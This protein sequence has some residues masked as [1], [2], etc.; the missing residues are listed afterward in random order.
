MTGEPDPTS[1]NDGLWRTGPVWL[2]SDR[3]LARFVGRPVA[4]FLRVEAAGGIVLLMAAVVALAWANSP[5][6][7]S[8][9]AL[10]TT[11]VALRIGSWELAQEAREWVNDGLM[12]LFFLAVGLEIKY[13][14]VSGELRD[15]RSAAVPIVAALGGMVVPAALYAALNTGGEGSAG[16]GIPMAT[17]IAF[18]LG[19]VALLGRRIP[20]PA[21]VFLLTLAIV[22]DIGAVAVIGI[23]Y[24]EDLSL[25]WLGAAVAGV[26][27]IVVLR[28]LRVWSL[29][30]YLLAGGFLWLA[31]ELS[32]VHATI[33]GVVLG[34]LAPAKPLLDEERARRY[35]RE[36]A[37]EQ[38]DAADVRRYR[39]LLGESVP[40]A[41]RLEYF[42]HPW[43]SFVVLP[44][45]ALANAG[46]DLSAEVL[47]DAAA[48]AVTAGVLLGLVVG[49]PLGI[50]SAS[51][52]TV[53]LGLGQL[54]SSMTWGVLSGL[55]ML[56]G[57]GFTVSLFI[58]GLAFPPG[59]LPEADAKVGIL[60]ASCLAALLGAATL[61]AASRRQRD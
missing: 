30:P 15:P 55:A 32:G 49:K 1:G 51:W 9:E 12:V 10:W 14:L 27:A 52:L 21:R 22:D 54:P 38:F 36:S 40:V 16:W 34:L 41:E 13:E 33:A 59:S 44:V 3:S 29:Y 35:A 58:A 19:V 25:A 24:T 43:S 56:G 17:D 4:A 60:A 11:D 61:L 23:F 7:A 8:Y 47:G 26:A 37:P 42:L 50:L 28:R 39:F 2:A 5:W 57:I 48:S 31:T 20:A 53:R 18:A 45:F 6:S 46:I